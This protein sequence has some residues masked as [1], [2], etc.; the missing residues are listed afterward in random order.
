M[1]AYLFH[2]IETRLD[3]S[4]TLILVDEGWL[5]LDD[6]AF[7]DQLRKWLKT[8]RK[9]N[10]AVV[11]ATQSLADVEASS[12]AASLIELCPSRIFLP[13]AH[14]AEPQGAAFYRRFGL[15]ERQIALIAH[16]VPKRDYYLQSPLGGRLFE[17]GLGPVA[18][19]FA[20]AS[21]KAEQAAITETL[22]AVGT[23][24]FARAWLG[25]RGL[26]WAAELLG[27]SPSFLPETSS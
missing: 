13:N 16:A 18:L 12:I 23:A 10:G 17:L 7:G 9:K 15:N 2:R 27:P 25:R 8:L 20:A 24:D 6:P 5:A 21:S 11:F 1:L 14:G 26:P 22:N 4:P 3:G 19:A